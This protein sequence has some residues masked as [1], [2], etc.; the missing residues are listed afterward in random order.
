MFMK[1]LMDFKHRCIADGRC[2]VH[3]KDCDALPR[4]IDAM[5]QD[6]QLYAL[7]KLEQM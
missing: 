3:S 5:S 6:S 7:M 4:S 1:D 2:V